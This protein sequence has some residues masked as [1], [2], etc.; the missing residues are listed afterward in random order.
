[1]PKEHI[2]EEFRGGIL[3]AKT[4]NVSS[5]WRGAGMQ[6]SSL[7]V[8]CSCSFG[9]RGAI[10]LVGRGFR[11]GSAA[12]QP[13]LNNQNRGTTLDLGHDLLI[14]VILTIHERS[15]KVARTE[16]PAQWQN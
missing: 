11:C 7:P 6:L 2:I 13:R 4:C 3:N 1:M 5:E 12:W 16:W 14:T 10:G 8:F 9:S 15:P